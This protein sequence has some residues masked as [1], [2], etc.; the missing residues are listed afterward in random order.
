MVRL[1]HEAE[2]RHYMNIF[3][4]LVRDLRRD[5]HEATIPKCVHYIQDILEIA[6]SVGYER[7]ANEYIEL[8][9]REGVF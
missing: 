7:L 8:F 3:L 6:R 5:G 4:E 9:R 2:H 1:L